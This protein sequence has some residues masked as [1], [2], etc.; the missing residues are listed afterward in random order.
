M[1]PL[2]TGASFPLPADEVVLAELDGGFD[3]SPLAHEGDELLDL[4][5]KPERLNLIDG[6]GAR[7]TNK[8]DYAR[9]IAVDTIY[10]HQFPAR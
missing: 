7:L 9:A 6:E 4:L 5:G 2:R 1:I 8:P 10:A 3:V